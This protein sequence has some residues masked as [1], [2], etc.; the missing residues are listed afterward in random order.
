MH[1]IEDEINKKLEIKR[2]KYKW[3]D[4]TEKMDD[5]H[6]KTNTNKKYFLSIS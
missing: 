1:E 4:F 6:G 2:E 3:I 5:I